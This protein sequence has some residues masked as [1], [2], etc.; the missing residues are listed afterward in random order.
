M[1]NNDELNSEGQSRREKEWGEIIWR[2]S[3]N[4]AKKINAGNLMWGE[5]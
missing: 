1:I 3:D 4:R 2:M 5:K